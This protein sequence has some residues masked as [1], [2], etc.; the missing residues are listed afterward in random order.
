MGKINK[1]KVP[2]IIGAGVII[3]G[4]FLTGCQTT[5]AAPPA[6]S[7]TQI[8]VEGGGTVYKTGEEETAQLVCIYKDGKVVYEQKD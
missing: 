8:C 4:W 2:I 3:L 6:K 7:F 5:P 1:Y